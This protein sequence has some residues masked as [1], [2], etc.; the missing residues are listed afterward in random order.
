VS[1]GT[2]LKVR[3]LRETREGI[4]DERPPHQ[5]ELLLLAGV[6]LIQLT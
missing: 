4:C 3:T 5:L 6:A 1:Q 2:R